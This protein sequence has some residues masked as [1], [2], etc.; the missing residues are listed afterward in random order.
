MLGAETRKL[1]VR[2]VSLVGRAFQEAT[3]SRT[4]SL[5]GVHKK[6]KGVV[7]QATQVALIGQAHEAFS[8]VGHVSNA[9]VTVN[10]VELYVESLVKNDRIKFEPTTPSTGRR[11]ARG[12]VARSSDDLPPGVT[13]EVREIRGQKTLVR[14]RFACSGCQ[15]AYAGTQ[16]LRHR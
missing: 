14:V 6:L 13:H 10:D 16:R 3:H 9:D 8:I 4:V 12:A 1:T 5:D 7:A 11:A 15:D 2:P